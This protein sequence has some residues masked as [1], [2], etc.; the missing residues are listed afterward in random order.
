MGELYEKVVFRP[1][2]FF[3][4]KGQDHVKQKTD[5]L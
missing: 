2:N 3:L 4:L 5:H 1:H